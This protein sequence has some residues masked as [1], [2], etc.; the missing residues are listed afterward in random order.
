M[1]RT[2]VQV[3]SCG[4]RQTPAG[5]SGGRTVG[6]SSRLLYEVLGAVYDRLGFDVSTMWCFRDLVIARI[7]EPTSKADSLRVLTDLRAKVVSYR[8]I[9]RHLAQIGPGG[10]RD[11]IATKCFA[12]AYTQVGLRLYPS[13][14]LKSTLGDRSVA[15][16]P[17]TVLQNC[18]T[19][20]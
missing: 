12:H 10:Y 7:A 17:I 11:L 20:Q 6:T 13:R 15:P 8:T 2:G 3:K 9:Q 14:A 1:S 16:P 5:V 18:D 19:S 4:P